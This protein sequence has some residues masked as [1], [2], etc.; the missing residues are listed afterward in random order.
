MFDNLRSK[1][2]KQKSKEELDEY[3]DKLDLEKGDI[4]A[5]IIAAIITFLPVAIIAMLVIYGSIW[6]LFMR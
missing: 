5:M 2:P 6:L 3:Y 4:P 1:L